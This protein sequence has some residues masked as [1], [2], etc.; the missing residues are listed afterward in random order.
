MA[1]SRS[2]ARPRSSRPV[3]QSRTR[4][5][6][7]HEETTSEDETTNSPQSDG[8]AP[9]RSSL[10]LRP[11]IS[12]A[13]RPSYREEST[14]VTSA[15]ITDENDTD[16]QQ[17]APHGLQ[18]TNQTAP[19][20][21]DIPASP[22]T[23]RISQR[24]QRRAP[25]RPRQV[26]NKRKRRRE[27][28]KELGRPLKK[29]AKADI[30]ENIFVSSGIIPPW[31]TLPYQVLLEIFLL[32]SYPLVDE[33]QPKSHTPAKWLLNVAVLCRSFHEPA[34]AALYYSPP[35]VS[36][37][38]SHGLL[39]LLSVPPEVLSMNYASKIR[40][41]HVDAELVLG[42][43]S[44][45]T[46]GYFDLGQLIMKTPRVQTIRLYHHEDFII[47]MPPW[48][49]GLSK[50]TYPSSLFSAI[51]T[52]GLLLRRWDWNGRFL[53]TVDLL[54]LMLETH[55][56]PAFQGLRKLGLVHLMDPDRES[57]SSK[58]TAIASAVREAS[59]ATALKS[60][61]ELEDLEFIECTILSAA[62]LPQLPLSIRSLTLC[63]CDR[64][65][66]PHIS[67]F[68]KTHGSQLRQLNL[69]HNRHLNMSFVTT[70]GRDCPN[71]EKFRMDISM[72]DWSSY[73]D[74]DPHFSDLL[75][76]SEVPTWPRALREI[77]LIQLRH[78]DAEVAEVFFQSL[79][80]A[81]QNLPDLRRL[82]I[83]AILEIGWR[84]RAN[85]RERWIGRLEKTFLRRSPP[86]NPDL[87]S[88]RKR[89]LLRGP[90]AANAG[91]STKPG[92]TSNDLPLSAK[93]QSLRLSHRKGNEPLEKPD[94]ST[95]SITSMKGMCDV[96]SI[97]IDNQRPTETQ[98]NENDFL[99]DEL[100]GDEEW[101]GDDYEP[102]NAHAW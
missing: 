2:G 9:R 20:V 95:S 91:E 75:I 15:E 86:P 90:P 45:P 1:G 41:L 36:G 22:S 73:H 96:V 54:P 57:A 5:Q 97:R 99:D 83:S 14:D 84:A 52:R 50:W 88:L 66:S 11:R 19:E 32:A 39:N 71:L 33:K 64:L 51:A 21:A 6:T 76:P 89:P 30:S 81:A 92:T 40:E 62:L 98:F 82:E 42:Y 87:R 59:L 60:L 35:L 47:G 68:L 53:E 102:S 74:T 25:N 69:S 63:N 43:K 10:S 48:N 85:F 17:V 27:K 80:D 100:S 65:F 49:L 28:G 7:Y 56:L 34:L 61:P 78:W 37:Y 44:G 38:K 46:L 70:L 16:T 93:R 67:E 12:S 101:D 77:E 18:H 3:R 23:A 24:T 8:D 31:H 13:V 79:I 4:V 55:L 72:H 26:N 29:R 94:D 58:E